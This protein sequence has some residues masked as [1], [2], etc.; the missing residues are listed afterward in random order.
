MPEPAQR[1]LD[2]T[3]R[4]M[5][6]WLA[7]QL[8][9][10]SDIRVTHLEKPGASGFSN[11][12]LLMDIEYAQGGAA[13]AEN[14]VVRVTP[15][16]FPVFPYYNI[17]QQFEIMR[18]LGE[19]SDVP[20]P[21][22]RWFEEDKSIL[23]ESFYVMGR[24]DG[25]IPRDNPPFAVEGFL[26]D[27]SPAEREKL[28]WSGIDALVQV[29]KLDVDALGL[30]LLE[31]PALGATPIERHLTYYER[32]LNWACE[33]REQPTTEAALAWLKANLPTDE[34]RSLIW[35]D[36]RI[37]NQIFHDF[38]VVSVLDW[39]MASLGNPECD[40]AWWLFVDLINEAG[41]GIPGMARPRLEGMPSHEETVARWEELCGRKAENL[42]FYK[43]FAGLRF[44]CVMIRVMGQQAHYGTFPMEA[45]PILERNNVVTQQLAPLLDLPAPQ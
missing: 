10:V 19:K 38:E 11:D 44:A 24:V 36:A 9:E 41:N 13:K 3:R 23:G 37:G 16:G 27:A 6:G 18:V 8:P 29:G 30:D 15:T 4:R 39:E 21:T 32:Y 20:V 45:K 2:L 12:T 28:W 40:L 42:H 33:G 14:L 26:F 17:R 22:M 5:E 25:D 31:M 43:V 1:D 35:G 7:E 34:P